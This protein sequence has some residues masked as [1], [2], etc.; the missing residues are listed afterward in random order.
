MGDHWRSVLATE[1]GKTLDDILA[2]GEIGGAWSVLVPCGGGKG[3]MIQETVGKW[4]ASG[5][6]T[7]DDS[8]VVASRTHMQ[9]QAIF[10]SLQAAGIDACL[11]PSMCESLP[12][13]YEAMKVYKAARVKICTILS[14][15]SF[16]TLD[17]FRGLVIVDEAQHLH[18]QPTF[19][20]H[21]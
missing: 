12:E 6:C 11:R 8:V 5:K 19:C 1:Y 16:K 14:L 20:E 10:E 4:M 3:R 9:L 7:D 18:A 15:N 13:F 21:K 17:G 2:T